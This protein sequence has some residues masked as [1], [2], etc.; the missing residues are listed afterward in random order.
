MRR[1]N[2]SGVRRRWAAGL[3]LCCVLVA[4]VPAALSAD[5]ELL[6]ARGLWQRGALI[7]AAI[8]LE[9]RRATQAN[10]TEAR[11]LLARVYLDLLQGE[12]AEQALRE[13]RT[14]GVAR[15]RVLLPLLRSLLQ[16]GTLRRLL[17]EAA[18][19]SFD[20]PE[21]QATLDALRGLAHLG[22]GDLQAARA[23]FGRAEALIPGHPDALLGLARLARQQND[24]NGALAR[25]EALTRTHP[26]LAA[27]W[28][29][30]AELRYA[31]GDLAG[32]DEALGLAE[33]TARNKWTPRLK[34]ALV[35][36]ERGDIDA[37]LSDIES[38]QR[39]LPR[40]PALHF[41]RGALMLRQGLV[42]QGIESIQE[43]R[44][45]APDDPQAMLV[46][47]R[48]ELQRSNLPA[49][50]AL[51]QRY[52]HAV[53]GSVEG[54]LSLARVLL[55]EGQ[56]LP[57]EER[58]LALV[59]AGTAPAPALALLAE[60]AQ[61]GGRPDDVVRWLRRAVE[62]APGD[63]DY[64]VRLASAMMASGE[65]DAALAQVREALARVPTHR[66]AALLE[67]K[68]LLVGAD[69]RTALEKAQALARLRPDD[70]DVLN[71]LGLARLGTRDG[72]GAREAFALAL[73]AHPD[74]ED[75][76]LNLFG[77]LMR[78]GDRRA[79]RT[80]LEGFLAAAPESSTDAVLA[81]AALDGREHG[82]RARQ[83]RIEAALEAN[84]D[85]PRLW[86][87]LA[88]TYLDDGQ[89][90]RCRTLLQSA[91]EPL[92][93]VPAALALV[94]EAQLAS[95]ELDAALKTLDALR[96]RQPDSDTA[97]LLQA[98]A[99]AGAGRLDEAETSL[100]R[101]LTPDAD[102]VQAAAA[103]DALLAGASPVEQ[104]ARVDRLIARAGDNR[105]ARERKAA[106]LARTGALRDAWA[107]LEQLHREAPGDAGLMRRLVTAM[108][109]LRDDQASRRVLEGWLAAH[110]RDHAARLMLAQV[111]TEQG[112]PQKAI[113]L[114][115][116][117]VEERPADVVALNDLAW[118]LRD[119]DP[120]RA[121][122]CAERANRLAPGVAALM[123]TLG[124]LLLR[125]GQSARGL[126]LLEQA[127]AADPT[128]PLVG[129]H[130]AEA[131]MASEREQEARL[132][133]LDLVERDFPQRGRAR[134]LLAALRG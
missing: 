104:L 61:I 102:P 53:P 70:A 24:T 116:E 91:P 75:A 55:R 124:T 130:Y 121:L 32:A 56:P 60:I 43:Y 78:G 127:H 120:Q 117:L 99:E 22:S 44:R 77:L 42:Q 58:L 96:L 101:G 26:G 103:L 98:R 59:D 79:A 119:E 131:L 65:A 81:L 37:A 134:E 14:L 6:T 4:H 39:E 47:A 64:R 74:H 108:H 83:R 23:A 21:R 118:L 5:N 111:E 113:A 28:E 110:P 100:A 95:G 38:T 90:Q 112:R 54:N 49:A 33:T 129:L 50:K 85:R 93:L 132:V 97:L 29:E 106:L 62:Q 3:A 63:A 114:L 115:T 19:E 20:D 73:A 7:D 12:R 128:D 88:R 40:F 30:L 27:G 71:A 67:L 25:L 48:A 8:L 126:A 80:T 9:R 68:A 92:R 41:A 18:D 72:D 82:E 122:L 69:A 34:R 13:A 52:L 84:P 76:A 105:L 36:I 87:A 51:L 94:A 86:L 17:D 11:L 57:A 1:L 107:V 16:Q 66:G 45:Y 15:E 2:A 123:D 10:D 46:L 109:A 89:P 35:R 133:L 31:R 125:A